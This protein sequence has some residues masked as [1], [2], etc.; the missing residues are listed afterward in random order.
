M[1]VTGLGLARGERV[2]AQGLA[3]ALEGGEALIV[4][5][6]NGAGK[7]TLLRVMAGFCPPLAGSATL[8]GWDGAV[9]PGGA[10][11]AYLAHADGLSPHETPRRHARFH[12]LWAGGHA[13]AVA[14]ALAGMGADAFADQ[15]ARR[16]SAGQ[17]RRAALARVAAS[18]RPIWLLDEPAAPLDAQG[19]A[20]LAQIVAQHRRV[21]GVVI[22]AAHDRLDWPDAKTLRLG[23]RA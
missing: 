22:A 23:G 10:V 13:D 3:F 16:L 1:R 18:G 11:A 19:R 14:P 12:T 20:A 8:A 7:T 2:L 4:E 6:P 17:R 5:G 21:G 15:P 9:A